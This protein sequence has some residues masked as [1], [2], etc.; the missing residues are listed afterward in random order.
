MPDTADWEDIPGSDD[1]TT[2]HQVSGLLNG[3]EYAF[4]I[5]AVNAGGESDPSATVTARPS[6]E[7]RPPPATI[8]SVG[9]GSNDKD[10]DIVWNWSLGDSACTMNSYTIEYKRSDASEWNDHAATKPNSPEHGVFEIYEDLGTGVTNKRNTINLQTVG[11]NPGEVGV[12]LDDTTYDVRIRMWSLVCFELDQDFPDHESGRPLYL[13]GKPT[14]FTA[15]AGDAKATLAATVA[16]RGPAIQKWQYTYKE[17]AAGTYIDWTDIADSASLT[18]SDKDVA[19]LTNGTTYTFKVRGVHEQ[20]AGAESDEVT[21]TPRVNVTP[22]FGVN[23]IADQTYTQSTAITTL[24]LPEA[25]GGNIPLTYT[26]TP[27]APAMVWCLTPRTA[28]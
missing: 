14:S 22:S 27:N 11:R 4:Q 1:T 25:T 16:Q 26:L 8:V 19:G 12:S 6:I 3:Y 24:T 23:T 28:P 7:G 17:G 10:L 2:T 21:V 5:R 18:I 15:T 9:P 13:L 20:G